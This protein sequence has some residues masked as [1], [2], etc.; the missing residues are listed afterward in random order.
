[1]GDVTVTTKIEPF[2]R[3]IAL[4][5]S[6]LLSPEAQSQ[7]IA[8][9]AQAALDDALATDA[10]AIGELPAYETIVDGQ[11]G[12]PLGSVS[13]NGTIVFNFDLITEV[14]TWIE[15]QIITHS[16]I[17]S[18]KDPHPGLYQRSHRLFVD[19]EETETTKIPADAKQIVLA[20]TVLYAVFIEP[21]GGKPGES[22]QAP[23]G[24]YQSI[25]ALGRRQFAGVD[26]SFTFQTVSGVRQP[27]IVINL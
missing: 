19:G 5:V 21:H 6:D 20:P 27:A 16:P 3:D 22:K 25:A 8:D 23:D 1:M 13:P 2:D 7:A 14:V 10:A 11:S 9:F 24:V 15:D 12:A 26:I 17:G 18:G 4:I